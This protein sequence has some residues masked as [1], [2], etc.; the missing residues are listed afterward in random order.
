[1]GEQ[2]AISRPLSLCVILALAFGFSS[3]FVSNAVPTSAGLLLVLVFLLAKVSA[4]VFPALYAYV[5]PLGVRTA[6]VLLVVFELLSA[7]LSLPALAAVPS[8]LPCLV[9]G[10]TAGLSIAVTG[11]ALFF[12]PRERMRSGIVLG[13]ALSMAVVPLLRLALGPWESLAPL[14]LSLLYLVV[15]A[16]IVVRLGTTVKFGAVREVLRPSGDRLP[17]GPSRLL[18]AD[19]LTIT[20]VIIATLL[21]FIL[22]MFES[23]YALSGQGLVSSSAVILVIASVVLLLY[24]ASRG[25]RSPMWFNAVFLGLMLSCVAVLLAMLVAPGSLAF[26]RGG[27]GIMRVVA[28]I[29]VCVYAIE[30]A[31]SRSLSPIFVC[32]TFPAL[33]ELSLG[34]GSIL[35]TVLH[36]AL[37][38]QAYTSTSLAAAL[39][40]VVA[41]V[42]IT[43][44][45][46]VLSGVG[47]LRSPRTGNGTDG[48]Q[49][50]VG[51]DGALLDYLM[52]GRGLSRREAQI[53][54]LFSQ[55]RSAPYIG[56]ELD[57]A[58]STVKSHLKR[59]YTKLDIHNKQDLL[60][61]LDELRRQGL[62]IR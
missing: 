47:F 34:V 19:G 35:N 33:V 15:L 3:N 56:R 4:L 11:S 50:P 58:E 14:V 23:Y 30:F 5:R 25:R 27:V 22:G 57:L 28:M 1:M 40:A 59:A 18:A 44:F 43:L 29:P 41:A 26:V 51:S 38:P 32:G 6:Y 61:Y 20:V 48:E 24:L 31:K 54:L 7:V 10:L 62:P 46:V 37:G 12:L 8:L 52:E 39:L 49:G 17:A 9:Q 60:D 53:A 42:I 45:V 55:G 16:L 13:F 21:A 2:R 36:D